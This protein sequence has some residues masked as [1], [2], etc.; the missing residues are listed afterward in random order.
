MNF[1][2]LSYA[3]VNYTNDIQLSVLC[4]RFQKNRI[5]DRGQ[6]TYCP[7]ELIECIAQ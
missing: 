6:P 4:I 3:Q 1:Q 5:F 7:V 2:M